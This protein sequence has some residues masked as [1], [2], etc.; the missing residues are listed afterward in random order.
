M[1]IAVRIADME[2]FKQGRRP[3][4][5]QA[6][7]YY[8]HQEKG[9]QQTATARCGDPPFCVLLVVGFAEQSVEPK[10]GTFHPC[11][12]PKP[13]ARFAQ[14]AIMRCWMENRFIKSEHDRMTAADVLKRHSLAQLH[15]AD[16][17]QWTPKS[18]CK[19]DCKDIYPH[20]AAYG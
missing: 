19:H 1:S 13:L 10:A 9:R 11:V 14:I 16:G 15:Q 12:L 4:P 18:D 2:S 7:V 3:R 20:Q 6:P 8:G 5:I 17:Q